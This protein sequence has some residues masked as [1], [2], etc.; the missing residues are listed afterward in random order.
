M[1]EES[2]LIIEL[3]EWV[4]RQALRTLAGWRNETGGADDIFMSVNLS[5]K[6]FARVGLDK[7]VVK[8][9][10]RYGLPPSCL[11]L[12][13]TESAIMGNPESSLRILNQL[14]KAGVRF[15]IDDF[16]TG[17]S[18]LSQ[19]QQLPVDT[20][21]VDRTFIARMRTDPENMEIVKA[22]IALGRS[23]DLNIIAEG[24]EDPDQLCSLLNLS[25]D[26]VQGFYFHE[27][28]SAASARDL[29]KQRTDKTAEQT[30]E[31]LARARRNCSP[32]E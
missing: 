22:V 31:K 23:L 28:M 21:K 19:L 5:S 15:S 20:L 14:R 24:V 1:A 32:D 11:K 9:L 8:A 7:I 12:E 16:G 13:I 26:C 2:G 25:C 29:L 6:Q 3:G 18:S 27:P 10:E 17:Y 30:R 4:L